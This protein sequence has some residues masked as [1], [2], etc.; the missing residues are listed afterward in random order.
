MPIFEYR[1]RKCGQVTEFL[2]QAGSRTKHKCQ[3]CGSTAMEKL[4]STFNAGVSAP[5]A[6][7]GSASCPTGTCPLS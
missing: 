4:F 6:S 5:S 2:E 1:C 3:K 7:T